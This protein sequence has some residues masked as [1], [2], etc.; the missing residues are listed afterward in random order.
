M[1]SWHGRATRESPVARQILV[2]QLLVVLVLVVDGATALAALDARRDTRDCARDEAVGRGPLGGRLPLRAPGRATDAEPRRACSRS[3]RRCARHRRRLRRRHGARP[4]PLHPSRRSR[5]DRPARSS[6]TSATRPRARSSPRS[7]TARSGRRSVPSCRWSTTTRSSPWSRSA[8][9]STRRRRQLAGDLPGIAWSPASALLAVGLSGAWLISRRLRRQTHGLG[10]REITRMYEY[11][12]AVL[13]A[14][15]EG[16]V[17]VDDE[18]AC[19]WSTRRHPL[20]ARCPTDV[21]RPPARRPRAAARA[22][23]G[24][25]AAGPR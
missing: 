3:P 1:R 17:L 25:C 24:G 2:L 23:R 14:V 12:R 18:G 4:D 19:S 22:G 15:R 13:G 6:V 9:P 5:A 21:G 8:S 20:A 7:T 16:L 11:Y 10:E